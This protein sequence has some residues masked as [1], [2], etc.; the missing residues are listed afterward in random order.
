[1]NPDIP[2][3]PS[4]PTI[5][6]ILIDFW[7]KFYSNKKIFR[8]IVSLFSLIILI[9]ITGIIFRLTKGN[10]VKITVKTTPTPDTQIAAEENNKKP[11]DLAKEE[12]QKLKI[13]IKNLDISQKRLQSPTVNFKVDF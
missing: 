4:K 1:M 12:L 5:R 10:K 11:L 13:E 2:I 6:Q 9:I 3:Q 7:N 8:I